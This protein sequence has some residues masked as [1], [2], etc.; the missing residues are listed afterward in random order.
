MSDVFISYS[1]KDIEFA[2]RLHHELEARERQPYLGGLA[3]TSLLRSNS[4]GYTEE[5]MA[6]KSTM[7]KAMVD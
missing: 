6:I 5:H 4:A 2:Q 3:G 1:R 7:E